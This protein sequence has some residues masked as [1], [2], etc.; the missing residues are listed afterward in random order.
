[1]ICP[2]VRAPRSKSILLGVW[3]CGS[4]SSSPLKWFQVDVSILV[5]GKLE[6]I[7]LSMYALM[8]NVYASSN[9]E[10]IANSV[11][12]FVSIDES[13]PMTDTVVLAEDL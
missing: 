5:V 12:P 1:M 6:V 3:N 13:D 2:H 10:V 4:A 9:K 7:R 8:T 11:N